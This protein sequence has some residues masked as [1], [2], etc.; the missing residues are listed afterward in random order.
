MPTCLG[1]LGIPQGERQSPITFPRWEDTD[2]IIFVVDSNDQDI[3]GATSQKPWTQSEPP[4]GGWEQ[5]HP[6]P[7]RVSGEANLLQSV[8]I[9]R[10]CVLLASAN[11]ATCGFLGP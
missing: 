3:A 11:S 9:Q 7:G 4:V 8:S 6:C 1:E 10:V 5:G 2:A